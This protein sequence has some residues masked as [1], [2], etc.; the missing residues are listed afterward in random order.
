MTIRITGGNACGRTIVSPKGKTARPTSSKIRQALFNILSEKIVNAT[1]LDIYAGSGII[2]FE[3]LSRGAAQLVQIESNRNL[4][5]HIEASCVKLDY[6]SDLIV[7]DARAALKNLDKDYF[8]V[9]FAD[10]PYQSNLAQS[11]IYLISKTEILKRDGVLVIEHPANLELSFE[12]TSL[13][14]VDKRIYGQTAVSF[15]EYQEDN[16]DRK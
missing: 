16:N 11:T 12:K 13:A 15:I 1:F 2:G 9:I 4:A 3:A 6:E 14:S 8:D 10:P 5:S 7:M